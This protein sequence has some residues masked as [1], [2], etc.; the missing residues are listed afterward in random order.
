MTVRELS[1][2]SGGYRESKVHSSASSST[3]TLT[4][5]SESYGKPSVAGKYDV[6]FEFFFNLNS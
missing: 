4:A 2:F 6:G 5:G 3:G 1:L